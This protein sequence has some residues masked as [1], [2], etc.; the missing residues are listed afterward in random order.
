MSAAR[1]IS[2]SVSITITVRISATRPRTDKFLVCRPLAFEFDSSVL[3]ASLR[4]MQILR[5]PLPIGVEW[6]DFRLM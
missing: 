4:T 5:Q 2:C 1:R 3:H 6:R